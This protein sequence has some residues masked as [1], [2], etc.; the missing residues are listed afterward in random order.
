MATKEEITLID[1]IDGS[2]AD[3]TV[4][5]ELDGAAYEIDLSTTHRNL[6]IRDLARYMAAGRQTGGDTVQ[7]PKMKP[8]FVDTKPDPHAVRIWARA[9]GIDI[10]Q[11]KRIPK[12]VIGA[13]QAAG[14]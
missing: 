5:F 3:S 7:E 13:F 2:V 1:D 14:N 4:S 8:V 12:D 9:N 6:L 11:G 10:P